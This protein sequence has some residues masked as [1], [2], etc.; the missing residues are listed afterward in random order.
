MA[1]GA[2]MAGLSLAQGLYGAGQKISAGVKRRKAE[3]EFEEYKVPPAVNTMLDVAHGLSSQTEIPGADIARSRVKGQM[4]QGLINAERS[5][6]SGTDALGAIRDMFGSYAG[7][8]E[9]MAIKGEEF[10]RQ[11]KQNEMNVLGKIGEYQS[12]AWM[13]NELYPYM[14][15]MNAAGQMDAAGGAN[16]QSGISS[17]MNLGTAKWD[18]DEQQRQFDEWLER[19]Y[20]SDSKNSESKIDNEA[21]MGDGRLRDS[22]Y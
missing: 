19:K 16:L 7:F 13:Y 14:Q 18:M 6:E 2:I 1:I 21:K 5:A 3:S 8:E 4:S 9:N 22:I 20:P 12:Q 10:Q 11:A 17:G 15:S